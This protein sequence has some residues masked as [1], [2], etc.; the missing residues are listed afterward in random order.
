LEDRKFLRTFLKHNFRFGLLAGLSCFSRSC[1]AWAL[2]LGRKEWREIEVSGES[3]VKEKTKVNYV[4]VLP[5]PW[6]ASTYGL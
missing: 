6:T 5:G 1:L 2:E 3:G 4:S